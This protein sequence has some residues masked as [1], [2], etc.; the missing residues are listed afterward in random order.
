M[1]FVGALAI[2]SLGHKVD[3]FVRST[4]AGRRCAKDLKCFRRAVAKSRRGDAGF[5]FHVAPVTLV[6]NNPV[7]STEQ[8]AAVQS[9][10]FEDPML[11]PMN[12][13]SA[14]A[15]GELFE[16]PMITTVGEADPGELIFRPSDQTITPH[17]AEQSVI[18]SLIERVFFIGLL[19][20]G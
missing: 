13:I 1:V 19:P 11:W 7:L 8:I 20:T 17:G 12:R 3:G 10:S 5:Q 6:P 15:V 9:R 2:Q 16:E 18:T 14:R 4:Q